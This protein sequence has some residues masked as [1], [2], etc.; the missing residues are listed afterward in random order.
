MQETLRTVKYSVQDDV[1]FKEIALKL[2]R[3][4]RLMLSQM[5]EYFYRSNK[6]P[7]DL[8][9]ELLK[10]TILK[11]QKEYI[12]FIKTQDTH[13]ITHQSFVNSCDFWQFPQRKNPANR[14]IAGFYTF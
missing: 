12:G 7:T 14:A 9:D 13:R 4:K 11:G 2:C 8:N 5:V 10:N 6:D 1:K 3:S